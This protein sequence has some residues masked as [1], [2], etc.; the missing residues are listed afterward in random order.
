M[1]VIQQPTAEK[2]EMEIHQKSEIIISA[3]VK[4]SEH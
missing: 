1:E 2:A 3:E 4:N